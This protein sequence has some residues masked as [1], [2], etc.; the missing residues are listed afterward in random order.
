MVKKAAESSEVQRSHSV[1]P[2]ISRGTSAVV[3]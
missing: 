1:A 3:Y 2:A